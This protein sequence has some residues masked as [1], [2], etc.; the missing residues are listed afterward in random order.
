MNLANNYMHLGV[1]KLPPSPLIL[2]YPFPENW[3]LSMLVVC[4][5]FMC[6]SMCTYI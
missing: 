4:V 6:T 2:D 3:H 5:Y 1:T